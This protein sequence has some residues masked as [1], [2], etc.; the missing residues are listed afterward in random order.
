MSRKADRDVYR[1]T[2]E[3]I[4]K[5]CAEI[6]EAWPKGELEKREKYLRPEPFQIPAIPFGEITIA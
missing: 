5:A 1:P 3:D 2:K 4:K 6:R